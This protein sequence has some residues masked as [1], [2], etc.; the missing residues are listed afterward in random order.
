MMTYCEY[1]TQR[2]SEFDNLP[3]FF[4]FGREQFKAEME[5]RGLKETDTDKLYSLGHCGFYLKSD[6]E[7]IHNWFNKYVDNDPLVQLM[8]NPAFAEDA[9]YTEMRNH[10]Y[11]INSQREFDVCNCFGDC[12]YGQSKRYYDYLT[13][14][15]YS[16]SVINS[17]IKARKRYYEDAEKF[18]WM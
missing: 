7:A 17:Y 8:N 14:C 15:G 10:E 11:C 1:K 5:E 13:D 18:E 4:A 12:E 9:F 16:E 2:Q 6:A 3:I